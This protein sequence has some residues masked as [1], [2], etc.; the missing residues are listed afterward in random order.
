MSDELLGEMSDNFE[1]ENFVE[2]GELCPLMDTPT[3][4]KPGEAIEF[5]LPFNAPRP[6]IYHLT[7][8]LEND[9]NMTQLTGADTTDTVKMLVNA[10]SPLFRVLPATKAF[11]DK[12]E[13]RYTKS[14]EMADECWRDKYCREYPAN[15]TCENAPMVRTVTLN[16]LFDTLPVEWEDA[17]C[18]RFEQAC[19]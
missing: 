3:V 6:G 4:I 18:D 14:I 5:V 15:L 10:H 8:Q 2:V 1:S 12:L 7:F 19:D 13:Y 11:C 16:W 17:G 9:V